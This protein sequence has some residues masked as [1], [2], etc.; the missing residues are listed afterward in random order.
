MALHQTQR[1]EKKDIYDHLANI[2]LD[3]TLTDKSTT[4]SDNSRFKAFFFIS[5][6][7]VLCLLL[8]IFFLMSKKKVISS[9]DALVLH[10]DVIK[11]SY[12]FNPVKKEVYNVD[13]N[14]LNLSQYS[15]LVF[16]CRNNNPHNNCAFRITL[17]NTYNETSDTYITRIPNKWHEYTIELSD[18]K[19]ISNWS[20]M[21]AL[22]F[23]IEEWNS[24][25]KQ[26]AVFIENIRFVK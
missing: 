4:S 18:F 22:T 2:Y 5:V 19:H 26:D 17:A 12:T 10:P 16:A 7:I 9:Q 15:S 14:K 8:V 23:S 20:A 25:E 11:I 21:K 6:T 3:S 13:L 1:M 24:K